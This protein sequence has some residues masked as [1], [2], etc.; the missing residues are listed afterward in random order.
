MPVVKKS[1]PP[2]QRKP[3]PPPSRAIPSRV[4]KEKARRFNAYLKLWKTLQDREE[5]NV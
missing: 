5:L 4:E 2:K 3:M 1:K